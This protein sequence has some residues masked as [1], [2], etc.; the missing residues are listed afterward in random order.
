MNEFHERVIRSWLILELVL[1]DV[2][3]NHKGSYGRASE[4]KENDKNTDMYTLRTW[5][6]S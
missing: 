6:D 4:A 5:I 2:K 3:A 1:D